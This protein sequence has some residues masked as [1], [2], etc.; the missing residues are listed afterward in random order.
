MASFFVVHV[1]GLMLMPDSFFT[2]GPRGRKNLARAEVQSVASLRTL[3]LILGFIL[4][5][6]LLVGVAAVIGT[7]MN[8]KG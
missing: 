6:V 3:C 7:A 4:V 2:D 1:I 8:G 5:V